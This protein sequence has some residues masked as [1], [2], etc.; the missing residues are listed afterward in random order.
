MDEKGESVAG[1]GELLVAQVDTYSLSEL[2][3]AWGR[4]RGNSAVGA[5]P[6]RRGGR[7]LRQ[8]EEVRCTPD[9]QYAI[10]RCSDNAVVLYR[11]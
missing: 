4:G 7:H 11:Y 2:V 9:G 1:Q 5:G 8:M 3:S 6:S 10:I